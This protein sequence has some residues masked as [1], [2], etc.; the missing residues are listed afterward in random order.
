MKTFWQYFSESVIIQ[1]G[2][3]FVLGGAV[4]YLAV[5]QQQVPEVLTGAFGIMIGFWFGTK[6][7]LAAQ[8]R[9]PD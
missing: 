4:V 2:L 5:T 3:T 8:Q 9:L 6:G 7:S 1:G